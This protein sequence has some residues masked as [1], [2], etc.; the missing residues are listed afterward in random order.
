MVE[1]EVETS[2]AQRLLLEALWACPSL[3]INN[4][5]SIADFNFPAIDLSHAFCKP[6][7][8]LLLFSR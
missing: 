1:L 8:L 7:L 4:K 5:H 2:A 6:V 3:L